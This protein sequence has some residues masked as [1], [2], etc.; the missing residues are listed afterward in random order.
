ML[1]STVV[2]L[3]RLRAT[4]RGPFL[5]SWTTHKPEIVRCSCPSRRRRSAA[6]ARLARRPSPSR[7]ILRTRLVP[8]PP[9][10]VFLGEA[11]PLHQPPYGRVAK[12]LGGYVFQK[13]A[14]LRDGGGR[15]LLHVLLQEHPGAFVHLAGPHGNLLGLEGVSPRGGP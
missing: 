3:P 5:P 7:H 8:A 4:E 13:A 10:S 9:P 11:E 12:A 6:R 15:A 14:S 2:F 1:E